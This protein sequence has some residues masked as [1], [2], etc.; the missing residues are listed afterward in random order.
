MLAGPE[1]PVA[2]VS[3]GILRTHPGRQ[4]VEWPGA[5]CGVLSPVGRD[6]TITCPG[7][8]GED[9]ACQ[10]VGIATGCF[11]DCVRDNPLDVCA[12]AFRHPAL[13]AVAHALTPSRMLPL[14]SARLAAVH[15]SPY[16][17]S[18]NLDLTDEETPAITQGLH[19]I[20]END[21]FPFS[22]LIRTLRDI[23]AKISPETRSVE[24]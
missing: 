16:L 20:V 7:Q 14:P 11:I 18:V 5:W 12:I 23:L 21:G 15:Y 17:Q 13:L 19:D 3:V 4:L 22:L 24:Q 10:S 2:A 9:A 6:D 1:C 8:G